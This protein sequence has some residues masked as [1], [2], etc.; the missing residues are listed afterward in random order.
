M[1]EHERKFVLSKVA[2]G[3]YL[4]PS[5]DGERLY[6][7]TRYVDGPSFGLE[8]IT[9]DRD[10]WRVRKWKHELDAW[11]WEPNPLWEDN[12]TEV[13]FHFDTRREAIDCALSEGER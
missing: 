5:N 10:F 6:R 13:A 8:F 11:D 1:A 2:A 4:L 7:I 12:W 3:D 9:A